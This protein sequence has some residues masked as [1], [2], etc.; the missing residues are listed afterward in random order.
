MLA[1]AVQWF[2][3]VFLSYFNA[4]IVHLNLMTNSRISV[5]F[6]TFY[7]SQHHAL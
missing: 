2:Q 7:T 5:S 3:C 1:N 4:I 6:T